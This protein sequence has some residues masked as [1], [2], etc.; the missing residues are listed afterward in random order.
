[1]SEEYEP[2][3][4]SSYDRMKEPE[5]Y[6]PR[7]PV[8]KFG[9]SFCDDALDGLFPCDV[10]LL[11]AAT[12][13]GKTEM[14]TAMVGAIA[15]QGKK[16]N[17]L[18]LEADRSEIER[19]LNYKEFANEVFDERE[20]LNQLNG[21]RISFRAWDTGKLSDI[22]SKQEPKEIFKNIFTSYRD[23]AGFSLDDLHMHLIA[24]GNAMDVICID[25]V[26]YIDLDSEKENAELR[27]V[28][29]LIRAV[30]QKKR[31]PMIVVGHLRKTYQ[32]KGSLVPELS[33][34]HGSSDLGKIATRAIML[35][36]C[37]DESV[38]NNSSTRFPTF[39]KIEKNRFDGSV[40]RYCAVSDF[41][42]K[43]SSYSKKYK[44]GMLNFKGDKFQLLKQDQVP[45]WAE[46]MS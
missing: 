19:R 24:A 44:L 38:G 42:I 2:I 46:N 15:A 43:T 6:E 14:V 16:V 1:M 40:T 5:S 18:A 11:G 34:F 4:K 35:A 30:A 10:V 21:R 31:V 13:V 27:K 17:L 3:W 20:K 29:Q 12:G 28:I 8:A 32:N 33:E 7:I 22:K 36:P 23:E 9:V 26:H 37:R 45:D 41:D 39:I 25:H